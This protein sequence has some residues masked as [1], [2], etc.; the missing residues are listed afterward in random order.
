MSQC[1]QEHDGPLDF[2]S[3]RQLPSARNAPTTPARIQSSPSSNNSESLYRSQRKAAPSPLQTSTTASSP[4]PSATPTKTAF[5][6]GD[7]NAKA[8]EEPRSPKE[9]LDDLLAS[10]KSFYKSEESSTSTESIPNLANPK[11]TQ[12]T[13]DPNAISRSVSDPVLT[14]KPPTGPSANVRK[15]MAATA[16][17]RNDAARSTMRQ[18]SF[19]SVM[20]S[21]STSTL[22]STKSSLDIHLSSATPDIPTLIQTA[23]SPEAVI[24]FLLKEKQSQ[25]AQNTQLWRLVDK[26]RAM[27]LGLNKDLERALKDK[28]R[29]RSKLKEKLAS[30]S[31][32]HPSPVESTHGISSDAGAASS[33]VNA[34]VKTDTP[35]RGQDVGS[36]IS[37]GLRD[38]NNDQDEAPS[39]INVA[40]APYPITPPAHNHQESAN[41]SS[42]ASSLGNMVEAEHKMPS[43]SKHAFQQYNPDAPAP[44]SKDDESKKPEQ[45]SRE[46]PYNA[47]VP[48]SRSLPPD[49]PRG[50]PPSVPPPRAPVAAPT[51]SVSVIEATPNVDQD[52]RTFPSPP[53]K[54]P[55]APLNLQ[56]SNNASSHLHQAI[57]MEDSESDYDDILEVDEIP[58]FQ[59]RGRRKTREEDDREREIA[60]MRDKEMRS[61]S[62]KSVKSGGKSSSKSKPTTPKEATF[63]AAAGITENPMPLSPRH[64]VPIVPPN[65][66]PEANA[67][68]LAGMLS[69]SSASTAS[70]TTTMS[71]PL[72]S[73]GLP[74][75]PRPSDRPIGSPGFPSM[76]SPPMSPR[77]GGFAASVPLS[78]RAPR[79]PIPLPP[80]TPMS[81]SSPGAP[82]TEQSQPA[83]TNQVTS[84]G[85]SDPS[86]SNTKEDSQSTSPAMFSQGG[87]YKGLVDEDYP[88]LLLPPN[89]LP[90]IDVKVASSRLKPSRASIMFGAKPDEDPVFTLAV[91]S[92]SNDRELWRLEKDLVSLA[93]LDQ[94]L[95]KS[96]NY[97]VRPPE[98]SL[99][100]GH[101]PAKMDARRAALEKYLDELLN[102]PLDTGAAVELCRY[103]STNAMD[104]HSGDMTPSAD[105]ADSPTTRTGPGGRPYKSGYLTKRGKNFG[106]WKARFFVLDGPV[107]KYYESPGGPHLGTIKLQ[108]A[109]IG[110]QQS[111]SDNHSPSRDIDDPDN[112]YRHA[113]LILEPKRKDSSSL[114]RHVLCAESDRERDEWVEALLQYVD[115][116]DGED[117]ERAHTRDGSSGSS[118]VNGVGSKKKP[119]QPGQQDATDDLRA[120]SYE[121]TKQGNV[122][123]GLRQGNSGTPSPPLNGN[124]SQSQ[125]KAISGPTNAHPIQDTGAWGN[126]SNSLV[127][128]DD[129]IKQKKRS[130]FG[131]GPKPRASMDSQDLTAN[132]STSNLSQMAFEQHG[133]IRPVFGAPLAE[134]VRY[135][136]PVDVRIEL[137]AVVYR[138]IE[139]LDSKDAASEEGIFRLSGSNVVIRQLRERFNVEGD[140]NLVND[141]QYYDIHAVASLLKLY[142]RELP[143]TILT[144]ELHLEFLAVTE[145]QDMPAKIHALNILVHRLPRVNKSLLQ[146]LAGFLINI[147]SHSDTNKMTVRNVGIVFS[148][149][150]NI[151]APVFALFLQQ[152][153]A[154][155]DAEPEPEPENTTP[156]EV[157]ITA[158]PLTPEDIRSP[159]K[160]MFQELPTPAYNQT[161]FQDPNATQSFPQPQHYQQRA[162][163]DTGFTPLQQTYENQTSGGLSA[164]AA[165]EHGGKM[166]VIAG[167]SYEQFSAGYRQLGGG[168]G[169]NLSKSKRRESSMF[170]MGLGLAQ[171]KPSTS[172]LREESKLVDEESFFE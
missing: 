126:K 54:A 48:P 161:S 144:R 49:A 57:N 13:N 111:Q 46:M 130:F 142:L 29:Y 58:M 8:P 88:E 83:A 140:V 68:S 55:P 5:A 104:P 41:A 78:P 38:Q 123:L 85:Q 132:E 36:I 7:R 124:D 107:F 53:R 114:V 17:H 165:A 71:P 20:S 154:I 131:F 172:K 93:N 69:G 128:P 80:N 34:N 115:Y 101:A 22:H 77:M 33:N 62:K 152:F 147:V 76:N 116:L 6:R 103:L 122:P 127:A 129:K 159:R 43:P 40:L 168:D 158:P 32:S 98:R 99:F 72:R 86:T 4:P 51:P 164:M 160:Q 92:R 1:S 81:I 59:E 170:G 26:Q 31:G 125:T 167:P 100:T 11:Y 23:G 56:K 95:K 143:T 145:L 106:G 156:V 134:A 84:K 155:F 2:D 47:S 171:K 27:I 44:G 18:A 91:Y 96:P 120:F 110:K 19:D 163:Y 89:A 37:V 61:L 10:E 63:D 150:L 64:T 102:T 50:P 157:T 139:Y 16:P 70:R 52:I 73:P 90:S 3:Q 108:G 65:F 97:R 118:Q 141:E 14:S 162:V 39:P 137:P 75:S 21:V 60:A 28:D 119:K 138:C 153:E 9:R 136:H 121:N 112:Q 151:P 109:Q 15:P 169:Q 135:N 82:K 74:A 67:G 35:R 148:P 25:A 45:V 149:T 166:P 117:E 79:Q 12:T 24:Q 146:Y 66:A 133:P 113:F 42:N 30:S 105:S 87:I 94:I